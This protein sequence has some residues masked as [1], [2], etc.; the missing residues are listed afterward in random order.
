MA[1]SASIDVGAIVFAESKGAATFTPKEFCEFLGMAGVAMDEERA[2]E[3][4]STLAEAGTLR[5][6]GP[7]VYA[8]RPACQQTAPMEHPIFGEDAR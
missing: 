3:V 2:D 1:G 5:Q 8:A 4:L 6:V 7:G